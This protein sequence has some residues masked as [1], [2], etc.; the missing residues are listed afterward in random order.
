MRTSKRDLILDAAVGIIAA[1]GIDAVTYESL[2]EAA[3]MSKSG[4]VYHFPSR[5]DLLLGIHR[6][7]AARWEQELEEA[8]G[9]AAS[10]VDAMT[11][12]RAVVKTLSHSATRAELMV[13]LDVGTDPEFAEVWVAVDQR[14]IPSAAELTVG[15]PAGDLARVAYLVQLAADGLWVHDHVH[16]SLTAAQREVLTTALLEMIPESSGTPGTLEN[17]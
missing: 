17:L 13:Q 2:A 3:G 8:A 9:G 11:R 1:A 10:E 4:M 7:L 16:R 6:H 5:R 15:G 14:W 12:L